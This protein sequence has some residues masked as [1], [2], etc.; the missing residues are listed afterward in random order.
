MK[1]EEGKE[2]MEDNKDNIIFISDSE[3]EDESEDI[4]NQKWG[5]NIKK[6]SYLTITKICGTIKML[7]EG[8][9]VAGA[10]HARRLIKLCHKTANDDRK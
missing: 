4:I 3:D 10:D 8:Y 5:R 2:P 7:Q 9:L 6:F 1:V